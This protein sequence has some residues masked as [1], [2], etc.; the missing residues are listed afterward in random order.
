[1]IL[2]SSLGRSERKT[3]SSDM[4]RDRLPPPGRTSSLIIS[5]TSTM[6]PSSSSSS[7]GIALEKA[8][9]RDITGPSGD[10]EAEAEK[11]AF[12]KE[13][14][15]NCETTY[16]SMLPRSKTPLRRKMKRS[17]A[18]DGKLRPF[19]LLKQDIRNI[20]TRYISDWTTFNQL[21]FAN[22]VYIFF[23][24]IL[25]GLT[26]ASDLYVSTGMTWGTIEVMFSTGL[27]GIIFSL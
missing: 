22:A 27:C 7:S 23:T 16:S 21:V 15:Q 4:A 5:S 18:P 24:N 17:F 3:Q 25:P 6:V 20:R 10:R 9:E 19:R 13:F 11:T 14:H 1:V 8:K 12:Q 26:F 2:G